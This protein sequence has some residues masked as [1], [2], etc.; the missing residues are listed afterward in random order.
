M[1]T[2]RAL[3]GVILSLV[4]ETALLLT[5]IFARGFWGKLAF[6]LLVLVLIVKVELLGL[7]SAWLERR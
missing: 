5:A 3:L 4:A 1:I 6:G 2:A 7:T